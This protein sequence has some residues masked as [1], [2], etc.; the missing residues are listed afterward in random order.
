MAVVEA[1][2]PSFAKNSAA[3]SLP[4]RSTHVML[5]SDPT[6]RSTSARP[7]PR[8]RCDSATTTIDKYPLE[9]PSVI[10]RAKPTIWSSATATSAR[11]DADISRPRSSTSPTRWAHP[12][13]TSKRWTVSKSAGAMLRTS[14][15]APRENLRDCAV[16]GKVR[17]KRR[18]ASKAQ[19]VHHPGSASKTR[20]VPRA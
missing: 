14:I 20:P 3:P 2:K 6:S 12:L 10:A 19:Q 13:L 4:A 16:V 5:G 1:L 9:I 8:V 7:M 17:F 18:W 15:P 11:C